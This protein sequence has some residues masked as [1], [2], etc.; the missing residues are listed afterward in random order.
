M[1][2]TTS[3]V[4]C[5]FPRGI[6]GFTSFNVEESATC[7]SHPEVVDR[8]FISLAAG[9][10]WLNSN[11]TTRNVQILPAKTR[12]KPAGFSRVRESVEIRG[13]KY[14]IFVENAPTST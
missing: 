13:S 7:F 1:T 5:R 3:I 6:T 4:V 10:T 14:A 11:I 12:K 8:D 9:P 2:T